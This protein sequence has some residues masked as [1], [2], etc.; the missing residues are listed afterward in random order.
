MIFQRLCVVPSISLNFHW[1]IFQMCQWKN[2]FVTTF[3]GFCFCLV[4]HVNLKYDAN[5][6]LHVKAFRNFFFQ[7][8]EVNRFTRKMWKENLLGRK[9]DWKCDWHT[10]KKLFFLCGNVL[11]TCFVTLRSL[12]EF[13]WTFQDFF[14]F[15]EQS[16]E[17]WR[18]MMLLLDA[19]NN[20]FLWE[21][22][23]W[24]VN[25]LAKIQGLFR[26]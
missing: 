5:L 19:W 18:N 12:K 26:F 3:P 23:R 9:I 13:W 1:P 4:L 7:F 6:F 8:D 24:K 10:W 11:W 17:M 16:S 22:T 14:V 20:W 21:A 15:A 25:E 2:T